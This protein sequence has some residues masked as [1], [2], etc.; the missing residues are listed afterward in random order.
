M[1]EAAVILSL[2]R[3]PGV[4]AGN[5]R[6]ILTRLFQLG[7]P[8]E[9]LGELTDRQLALNLR[10]TIPQIE[11]WRHPLSD[12]EADLRHCAELGVE[13]LLPSAPQYPLRVLNLLGRTAPALLFAQGNLGLLT[14]PSLGVSGARRSSEASLAAV[15]QLC[16]KTASQGWVVVSGGARGA[17]E[18]AHLAAQRRGPGTIIVLPTGILNPSLRQEFKRQLEEGKTLLLSEFPPEQGWTVGCGMQRNRLLAA[19]SWAMALVEPGLKGGTGGTGRVALKVGVPFFI[20]QNGGDLGAGA[21]EF[22]ERGAHILDA[23]ASPRQLALRLLKSHREAEADREA[24]QAQIQ[25]PA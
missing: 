15:T 18:A 8:P 5:L 21:G 23:S 1:T 14:F 9:R 25:F 10:L 19:L 17:D 3:L 13:S 12:P 22:L 16:E 24:G 11:A 2:L 6:L 20:L 7:L 4:G